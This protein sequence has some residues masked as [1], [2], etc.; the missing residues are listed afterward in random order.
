[1]DEIWISLEEFPR[2][3]ISN[4]GNVRNVDTGRILALTFPQ[5]RAPKV[6]LVEDGVQHARSVKLLVAERFVDGYSELC[7]T[8][9]Q[10]DGDVHN[11]A[12][13]NL[14]WRPRWFALRYAKQ[15]TTEVR[16]AK[17]GPVLE[18]TSNEIFEMAIQASM[19]Y[20]ILVDDI[21]KSIRYNMKVWPTELKFEAVLK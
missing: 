21:W 16:Y 1:M 14:A 3:E 13:W 2:Y 17:A 6:G 18:T 5:G 8:P 10:L 15:F 19:C 20:G 11:V 4:H 9:I 7:N 12:C